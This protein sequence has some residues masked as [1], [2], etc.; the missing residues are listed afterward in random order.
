MYEFFYYENN[1]LTLWD[2]GL[3]SYDYLMII[4]MVA[5]EESPNSGII[6]LGYILSQYSKSL[7]LNTVSTVLRYFRRK[8]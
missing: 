1:Y 4:R 2:E 7:I 8:V 3:N 6:V 5:F